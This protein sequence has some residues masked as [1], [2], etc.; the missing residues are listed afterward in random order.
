MQG[1]T[2]ILCSSHPPL[3][4]QGVCVYGGGGGYKLILNYTFVTWKA[5]C[6]LCMSS[7]SLIN[8]AILTFQLLIIH[9]I[10]T[11]LCL[12]LSM[13]SSFSSLIPLVLDISGVS[14]ECTD[15]CL[16]DPV[17]TEASYPSGIQGLTA[18]I[19][20]QHSTQCWLTTIG[21]LRWRGHCFFCLCTSRYHLPHNLCCMRKNNTSF[22]CVCFGVTG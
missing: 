19:G 20:C 5:F 16:P 4:H 21:Q 3:V 13:S 1:S 8:S 15:V 11:H 2:K 6:L 18:Q 9:Q 22:F 10:S 14:F 7:S 17:A 12:F